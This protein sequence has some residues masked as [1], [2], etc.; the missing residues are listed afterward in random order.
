MAERGKA[1]DL[2]DVEIRVLPGGRIFHAEVGEGLLR[3]LQEQGIDIASS[4]G[5]RG[6]CGECRVR[7]GD[8]APQPTA[9][10][11]ARLD[12]A[13]IADGWRL[14]CAHKIE[15]A[16]TIEVPLAEGELDHKA[17]PDV[18][19]TDGGNPMARS[20]PVRLEG[21]SANER[22]SVLDQLIGTQAESNPLSSAA[23]RTLSDASSRAADVLTVIESADEIIEVRVGEARAYGLAIDVGTTTLAVHILDLGSGEDVGSAAARN[24]QRAFGADVIS[25]IGHVRRSPEK[26]LAELRDAVLSGL[27]ELVDQACAK[28]GIEPDS[29]YAASVV[30][31]P[32]ML[33]LLLGVDP[34]GIDV[35][36]YRPAFSGRK[37]GRAAD[38]G[39]GV[40]PRGVVETL[41]GVSAYI[42]AD[43]V[44]GLL[45]TGLETM[46]GTTLFLDVGTN[47]EVVLAVDGRLLGCST[48]AGPA[49]EGASIVDGMPALRGAIESV[50]VREDIVACAVIGGTEPAGLCGTGLVS[51]V[52]E[53]RKAGI[54]EASGR[55]ADADVSLAERLEGEGK[56]R[57]FRLDDA[58]AVSLYQ[59]DVREYQLAKAAIR[60]G[61]EVLLRR[62]EKA[63]AELDRILVAGAFSRSL[64]PD[65]LIET[66]FL[67]P[68]DPS[69][70]EFAGNTAAVGARR[71]LMDQEL[72][73]YADRLVGRVE[74]IELSGLKEFADVYVECMSLGDRA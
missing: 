34:S 7:Y 41:P 36:P 65:H 33:H 49:F 10:D 30:G 39:L 22:R 38:L 51:A 50:E 18:G 69:R 64:S 47:G 17:S 62:A 40:H 12:E 9:S 44:A 72:G 15:G 66:G 52:A 35:N 21:L 71:F 8:G 23:L 70:V 55:F 13:A 53:L 56:A 2:G 6:A 14:A 27:N 19:A 58:G 32:T 11:L 43:I 37:R 45:A 3:V 68:V 29:L 25:R 24:P 48:A 28:A 26:G 46:R 61:L 1:P 67:P 16:A 42:G 20:R 74:Y 5:G 57:R 31:N 73:A 63:P 4:C 60:A 59:S 54:I